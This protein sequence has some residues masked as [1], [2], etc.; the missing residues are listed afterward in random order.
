MIRNVRD[1]G[2]EKGRYKVGFDKYG[3]N[4]FFVCCNRMVYFI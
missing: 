4:G 1:V 3:L 2:D